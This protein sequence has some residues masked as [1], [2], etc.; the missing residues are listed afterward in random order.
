V[1]RD[2]DS[3]GEI[4]GSPSEGVPSSRERR[5]R[6]L[7]RDPETIQDEADELERDDELERAQREDLAR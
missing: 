3:P 6:E 1:E 7:E 5:E 2:F 4:H